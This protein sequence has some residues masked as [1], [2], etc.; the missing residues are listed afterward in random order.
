MKQLNIISFDASSPRPATIPAVILGIC[1][2]FCFMSREH[3]N[4]NWKYLNGDD[5][6]K[7]GIPNLTSP[8][9][10]II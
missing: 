1:R 3:N 7:E 9:L 8:Q 4:S 10:N 5:S 2:E 6:F